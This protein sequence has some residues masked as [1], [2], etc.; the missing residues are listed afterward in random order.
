MEAFLKYL[1]TEK[2]DKDLGSDTAAGLIIM[3][4]KYNVPRLK[5][6][7]EGL[8]CKT[9]WTSNAAELL[10]LAWHHNADVLHKVALEYVICNLEE[11]MNTQEWAELVR[12]CP[13]ITQQ[14]LGGVAKKLRFKE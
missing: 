7:L 6:E 4:D 8:L 1:Y 11:V 14:V 10:M 12:C 5:K 2:L 9:L 3:A 13:D